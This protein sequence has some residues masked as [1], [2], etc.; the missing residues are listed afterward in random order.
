MEGGKLIQRLLRRSIFYLGADILSRLAPFFVLP[1][2][3]ERLGP[4]EFGEY[5]LLLTLASTAVILIGFSTQN[6]LNIAFFKRKADWVRLASGLLTVWST[7]TV[8]ALL[9]I[10][11]IFWRTTFIFS[12][13]LSI[14]CA[15]CGWVFQSLITVLHFREAGSGYA[16][17]QI[18]RSILVA[19]LPGCVV[20]Y[21]FHDAKLV[22]LCFAVAH[23][24]MLVM[25]FVMLGRFGISVEMASVRWRSIRWAHR[26]A[27][28]TVLNGISGWARASF[29]RYVLVL[30]GTTSALGVYSLGFQF[31]SILGIAGLSLSKVSSN[32]VLKALS[33]ESISRPERVSTAIKTISSFIGIN[34]VVL[35]IFFGLMHGFSN[36][37]FS[38]DYSDS[39]S[40]ALLVGVA[41]FLQSIASLATP[42]FQYISKGAFL[43][44]LAV[45]LSMFSL[46]FVY[47]MVLWLSYFGAAISFLAV[48]II[49][50]GIVFFRL[51]DYFRVWA[52]A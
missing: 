14:V 50:A 20:Y 47:L 51:R 33:S 39:L 35:L 37:L 16:L 7:V 32:Y 41:F 18:V 8:L 26:F 10:L 21:G 1:F 38:A 43:G 9:I 12:A 23:V 25:G 15:Y 40:I 34:F 28:P 2:I 44:L 52:A 30:V 29:D 17:A 4:I 5:S 19:G 13:I 11:A 24:F 6:S 31:G 22:F 46:V 3:A 27:L 45:F 42:C 36:V 48:W 49:H